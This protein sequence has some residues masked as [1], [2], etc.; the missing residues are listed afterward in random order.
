MRNGVLLSYIGGEVLGV[1]VDLSQAQLSR[2]RLKGTTFESAF[3]RLKYLQCDLIRDRWPF[4]PYS[5]GG[6][7]NVHFLHE[8]L[9]ASFAQ[10]L[11]PGGYLLLETVAAHGQNFRQLP[12]TGALRLALEQNGFSAV[13]YQERQVG[14]PGV[15]A[16]TVKL[17][18]IKNVSST[19]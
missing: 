14:S 5:A 6:I 9:L 15:D 3:H 13:F 1:D 17:L 4:A 11:V 19:V 7:I 16:S 2:N 12:R 18:A 10:T 8:P